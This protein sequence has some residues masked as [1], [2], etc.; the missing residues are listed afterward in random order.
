MSAAFEAIARPGRRADLA[1][2]DQVGWL[3][4]EPEAFR[5][6]LAAAG[7][8]RRVEAGTFLYHAGDPPNGLFGLAEG[9]LDLTFPLGAE[10]PV[11]I[12][13]AEIGFWVG[14]SAEL[15]QT[16]RMVSIAAAAPSRLFHVPGPA[17]RRLL[18]AAPERWRS[19]Y[20][21]SALQLG[22]A[23]RLLAESLALTVRARVARRLL[24]LGAQTGDV[25]ITQTELAKLVGVTRATLQRCLAGLEDAGAVK[26][27]YG[28]VRVTDAATLA[29]FVDEQ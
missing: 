11:T 16:T 8:W 19:L 25:S 15:S 9:A 3:A 2:L 22:T 21:L 17:L 6:A 24:L 4:G 12:H 28:A 20:R 14:D 29:G 23:V 26:R 7:R 1:P 5:D 10:E 13:R 27:R 18:D